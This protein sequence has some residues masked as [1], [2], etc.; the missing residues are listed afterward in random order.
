M[1][2]A[3]CDL[4]G[5]RYPIIQSG[6]GRVASPE[7]VAQVSSGGGLG[8]LAG[9][10]LP[11][12]ELRRQIARVRA[13]TDRPFGVNLWLHEQLQPPLTADQVPAGTIRDVQLALNVFRERLGLPA[14]TAP[15]PPFPD[16]IREAFDVIID[17][18]V[19]VWSIGLGNPSQ[20]MV[21]RC[22]RAG[23]LVMAMVATVDDARAVAASGVDI[24][25][26][27][28][29]EAGGHRST[30]QKQASADAASIGTLV[31]VPQVVDAVRQPVVAAGG[32]ADGR[33]VVA[34]LALGAQGALLGT[35]FVAT[36]E[37]MAAP[38]YK[39]AILAA[40]SEDT[41]I[42]DAFTGL[43]ARGI[44]N[45]FADEYDAAAAPVLP[46]LL[47]ARA[48]EDIY[49]ASAGVGNREY[50]PLWAGQSAGLIAD[51]DPSAPGVMPGAAD[52]L[53]TIVEEAEATLAKLSISA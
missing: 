25:V 7:L 43:Y 40:R 10:G 33:G 38:M 44:R 50:F 8:I 18:H 46:S 30:W 20:A 37:S 15:P 12:E 32:I 26:A 41:R 48:A 28:G 51:T 39:S 1:R 36:R 14:T 42:T 49:A 6:M 3:L 53:R 35:R 45:T 47:Q 19:P 52:V 22:H 21:D 34:A 16:A 27:Q 9:L 24:I 17:E 31:L 13:L 5:V 11:G 4:L 2:T 29:G 23:I